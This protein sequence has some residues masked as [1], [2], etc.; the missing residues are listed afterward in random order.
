M[1]KDFVLWRLAVVELK[2]SDIACL[3]GIDKAQVTRLLQGTR[4]LKANEVRPLA[5]LLKVTD[6]SI[7]NNLI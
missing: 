1:N 2:Q 6:T 4:Q 5:S 7:L 3:L